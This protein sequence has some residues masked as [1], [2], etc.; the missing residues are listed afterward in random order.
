MEA[1]AQGKVVYKSKDALQNL[2]IKV[3]LTRVSAPRADRAAELD[4]RD[5]A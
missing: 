2:R 4:A 1:A 5:A 3:S